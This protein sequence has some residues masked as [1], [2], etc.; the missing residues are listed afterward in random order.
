MLNNTKAFTIKWCLQHTTWKSIFMKL[1]NCELQL[2]IIINTFKYDNKIPFLLNIIE[3][4]VLRKYLHTTLFGMTVLSDQI[5]APGSNHRCHFHRNSFSLLPV[6]CVQ[7]CW[8]QCSTC[9][10]TLCSTQCSTC[11]LNNVQHCWTCLKHVLWE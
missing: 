6:Q 3:L 8:P 11:L 9:L 4:R 7:T 1:Q 5:W 10:N 2:R